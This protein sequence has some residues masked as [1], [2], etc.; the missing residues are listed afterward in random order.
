MPV[1]KYRIIGRVIDRVSRRGLGGLRVEGWDHD[2]KYREM[3]GSVVTNSDGAF[4][5][6]FDSSYFA[7]DAPDRVPEIFFRIY[8]DDRVIKSTI[9]SPLKSQPG[10]TR[11]TIEID[12]EEVAP[13]GKDRVSTDQAFKAV[14]F[15]QQSDFRGI[16]REG[17]DKVTTLARFAGA[18]GADAVANFDFEPIGP[19]GTRQNE[20]VGQ[21]VTTAQ[22]NLAANQVSVVEVKDYS[23]R[24]DREHLRAF[25]DF[26]LALKAGDR[27]TLYQRDGRVQYYSVVRPVPDTR[28]DAN[29]V[30]RIDKEVQTLKTSFVDVS[31]VREDLQTV[32][33]GTAESTAQLK[34]DVATIRTQVAEIAR[35]KTE[36]A[37]VR[38]SAADKDVQIDKMKVE[39]ANM[40]A[41]QRDINTRFSP[42]RLAA[43]EQQVQQLV[44]DRQRAV[45]QPE[46][47]A[48]E[49]AGKTSKP[50]RDKPR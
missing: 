25:A 33:V 19:K 17:R 44:K 24:A 22:R 37:A 6:T 12:Q 50:K 9:D 39:V 32:K 46:P 30:A 29:E 21:D 31:A 36:L 47:P 14:R 3:V 2:K 5:F 48:D 20:V 13:S 18:L 28:V 11:T 7:D 40:Q 45:T 38:Q 43:L 34:G 23:P 1:Q 4:S 8:L 49:R 27:V 26:P 15:V 41:A 42:D 35:L 16:W 10:D